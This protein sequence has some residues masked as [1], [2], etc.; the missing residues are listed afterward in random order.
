M[1]SRPEHYLAQAQMDLTW[2]CNAR[3]KDCCGYEKREQGVR[4]LSLPKAKEV[5]SALIQGANIRDLWIACMGESTIYPWFLDLL[6]YVDE[7]APRGQA[8]RQD[9]NGIFIP[10]GFIEFL[11]ACHFFYDLS[12]S[13]WAYDK[14][15]YAELHGNNNFD[16]VVQNIHR[17]LDEWGYLRFSCV[18]FSRQQV[19]KAIEFLDGLCRQHGKK[20]VVIENMDLINAMTAREVGDTLIFLRKAYSRVN[21]K[22]QVSKYG[23][24]VP[25]LCMNNCYFLNR[26]VLIGA[27]GLVHP[28]I[29]VYGHDYFTIG[30]VNDF[31]P[32][33]Y[34]GLV[35]MLNGEKNRKFIEDN[36]EP[37]RHAMGDFCKTCI[38]RV[39]L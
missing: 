33:T 19:N 34:K 36:L 21:G 3:C 24:V 22:W 38:S 32:F 1:H 6:K 8:I 5:V 16:K 10:K 14:D 12:V 29:G 4:Q 39:A 13:F 25:T 17:Y 31:S 7:I 18:C 26:N 30:D 2:A 28:C 27:N 11:N 35:N 23:A 20:V 37:A 15:S 9:T